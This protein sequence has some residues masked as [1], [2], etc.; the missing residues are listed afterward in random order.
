MTTRAAK[1]VVRQIG[2]GRT[3]TEIA[4]D[5]SCSWGVINKAMLIYGTALL[6]ADTKRL[7][8]TEAVGL[9]E[10]LF[11]KEGKFK[12]KRW[13]TTVC[14]V[15][16]HQLIDILPTRDY[17]EIAEYFFELPQHRR[18]GFRYGCLDMSRTYQAVY[19]VA[20][21]KICQIIDRFHVI[22]NANAALDQ[23]RRRVQIEQNG[24]RGRKGDPLYRSRRLLVMNHDRLDPSAQERLTSL[25]SLGDPDGEVAF[26]HAVK[27]AVCAFYDQP[28]FERATEYLRDIIDRAVLRSS[29][30]EVRRFGRT[31]QYW[32]ASILNWHVAK[33]SNGCPWP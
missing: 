19:R 27:E 14:D 22:K 20:T 4:R 1:W 18:E 17:T 13:S 5:L 33:H 28:T 29:P 11:A 2:D 32:F 15:G 31:L 10:T 30:P 9:D 12:K 23:V 24:H 25:L 26:A 21:P 3:V 6:E 8:D 16:H 7:V